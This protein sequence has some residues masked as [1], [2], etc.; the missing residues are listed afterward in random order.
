MFIKH[1]KY[2]IAFPI[3]TEVSSSVLVLYLIQKPWSSLG[4]SGSHDPGGRVGEFFNF[5]LCLGLKAP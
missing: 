1:V 3:G 4:Q 2:K 5:L